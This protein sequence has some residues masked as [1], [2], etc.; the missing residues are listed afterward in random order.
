MPGGTERGGKEM[1]AACA[2]GI[3]VLCKRHGSRRKA[4][5]AP[6]VQMG[7]VWRLVA[8]TGGITDW[9]DLLPGKDPSGATYG[10][11]PKGQMPLGHKVIQI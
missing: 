7:L 11:G 3:A 4:C 5:A 1:L 8:M 9:Q 10:I 2:K 6:D